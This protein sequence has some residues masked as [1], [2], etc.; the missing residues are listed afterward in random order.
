MTARRARD[1]GARARKARGARNALPSPGVSAREPDR[2]G[3]PRTDSDPCWNHTDE[4]LPPV[5]R[6]ARDLT[7]RLRQRPRREAR[8]GERALGRASRRRVAAALAALQRDHAGP[9]LAAR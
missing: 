2:A 6:P 7:L 3:R 8:P 4:S 1:E 5:L 9:R